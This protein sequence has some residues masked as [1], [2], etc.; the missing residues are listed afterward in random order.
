MKK[1]R[2]NIEKEKSHMLHVGFL[3]YLDNSVKY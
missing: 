2:A 1:Q 3:I